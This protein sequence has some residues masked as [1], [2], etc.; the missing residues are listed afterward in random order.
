[1]V[2]PFTGKIR[3]RPEFTQR[4]DN[5]AFRL[6]REATSL[7]GA[8]PVPR[9]QKGCAPPERRDAALRLQNQKL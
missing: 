5:S 8:S 3:H 9:K 7:R 4:P 6:A 2:F 1:M